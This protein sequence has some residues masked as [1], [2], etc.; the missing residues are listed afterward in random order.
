MTG[1]VAC[2]VTLVAISPGLCVILTRRPLRLPGDNSV[3]SQGIFIAIL[4]SSQVFPVSFNQALT[5][6]SRT[7]PPILVPVC[8]AIKVALPE[9]TQDQSD[10]PGEGDHRLPQLSVHAGILGQIAVKVQRDVAY[11]LTS[12]ASLSNEE[13]DELDSALDDATLLISD[14]LYQLDCQLNQ[15]LITSSRDPGW[16]SE[17]LRFFYI[18]ETNVNRVLRRIDDVKRICDKAHKNRLKISD[19]LATGV[20]SIDDLHKTL[21]SWED[22]LN[23]YSTSEETNLKDLQGRLKDHHSPSWFWGYLSCG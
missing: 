19:Q 15:L 14:Q 9:F 23:R 12:T 8:G 3:P 13:L 11:A 1:T 4:T 20:V 5:T 6:C 18:E 21:C 2:L 16:W 22:Q 7:S 17:I 10:N